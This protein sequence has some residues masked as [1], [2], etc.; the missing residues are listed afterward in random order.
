VV[1]ANRGERMA[2]LVNWGQWRQWHP[3]SPAPPA[4]APLP[5]AAPP[6]PSLT[7]PTGMG[8]V[9]SSVTARNMRQVAGT[10]L[11]SAA[12]S[13]SVRST[14]VRS[15][16]RG[17]HGHGNAVQTP[18]LGVTGEMGCGANPA[19]RNSFVDNIMVEGNTIV[20]YNTEEGASFN[21][22]QSTN[23]LPCFPRTHVGFT[24]NVCFLRHP[25]GFTKT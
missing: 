6:P 12:R 14:S 7:L 15:M 9:G 4:P 19:M 1:A 18:P 2:G 16:A 25:W 21:S 11:S 23:R 20:N 22:G 8:H 10:N 3:I 17:T 5:R 13:T 24:L